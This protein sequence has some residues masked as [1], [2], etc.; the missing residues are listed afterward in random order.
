MYLLPKIDYLFS[1]YMKDLQDEITVIKNCISDIILE[2]RRQKTEY[3]N[4]KTYENKKKIVE[5]IPIKT[6]EDFDQV[7]L[8]ILNGNFYKTFVS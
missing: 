2:L 7:N 1:H 5:V 3:L 6:F 4:V 8:A